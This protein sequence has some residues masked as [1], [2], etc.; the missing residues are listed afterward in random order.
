MQQLVS[1]LVLGLITGHLLRRWR[2]TSSSSALTRGRAR[3]QSAS[4]FAKVPATGRPTPPV[5]S[6]AFRLTP[7]IEDESGAISNHSSSPPLTSPLPTP[8]GLTRDG[9]LGR[10]S[11]EG[12]QG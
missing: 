9:G 3:K 8:S 1:G 4:G 11:H 6:A 2:R 10:V 7:Y 12:G 5:T